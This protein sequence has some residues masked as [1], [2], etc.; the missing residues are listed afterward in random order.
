[1]WPGDEAN[2]SVCTVEECPLLEV[3]LYCIGQTGSNLFSVLRVREVSVFGGLFVQRLT[4]KSYR[5]CLSVHFT[6]VYAVCR[7]PLMEAP[8]YI[9]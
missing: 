7:W 8:L 5:T 2:I 3:L 9:I 6:E 1:M 4:E